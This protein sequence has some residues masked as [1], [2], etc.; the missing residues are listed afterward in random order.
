MGWRSSTAYAGDRLAS[1][2]FPGALVKSYLYENATYPAALTGITD[3]N[4]MRYASWSYDAQGRAVSSEHGAQGSGIDRHT[5]AYN[6]NGSAT[7][8]DPLNAART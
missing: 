4:A 2:T 6:P 1:T 8:T 5:V 7:I 3:E